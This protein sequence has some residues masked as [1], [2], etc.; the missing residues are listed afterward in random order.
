[1]H[2]PDILGV[3]LNYHDITESK[4]VDKALRKSEEK[5]RLIF[6]YAPLGIL[7][8]DSAGVITTCND[9]FVK[10]IGSSKESLI[11]LN[12]LKLTDERIVHT[13]Q[14][15]LQGRTASFEGNYHSVTSN[16]TTPF[17][18]FLVRHYQ[19]MVPLKVEPA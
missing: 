15:A 19:K 3:L 7:H 16:K 14:E 2:V 1:M 5:F 10:I 9:N 4:Q 18:S 13:L 17:T 11:G 8:F 12:M 6:E